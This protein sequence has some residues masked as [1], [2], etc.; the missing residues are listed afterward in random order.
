MDTD[1]ASY[2]ITIF[3]ILAIIVWGVG[4]LFLLYMQM[5]R[6]KGQVRTNPLFALCRRS[7]WEDTLP[8]VRLKG[9]EQL[10]RRNKGQV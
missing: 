3:F 1:S 7:F 2:G 4:W 5:R 10:I 6:N 9:I 8:I